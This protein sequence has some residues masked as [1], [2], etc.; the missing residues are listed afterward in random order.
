VFIGLLM[1]ADE[2]DI[3][4][5]T[6]AAHERIIDCF[7]VLDGTVPN[8][9]SEA[10]CRASP[11]CSGYWTDADLPRP[12]Y[13]EDPVDGYRQVLYEAATAEHGFDHWFLLLHADEVWTFDPA[14]AVQEHPE[15]QG[16]IFPLPLYFPR[17]WVDDVPPL[18]QLRWSLRPGYP[19]LRMFRGGPRVEFHPAQH[20]DVT[21]V[22][23]TSKATSQRVIRHYAYRAPAVQRARAARHIETGFDPD[24]HRHIV[25]RDETIWDDSRIASYQQ[26]TYW[27]ELAC[28]RED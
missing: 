15:A 20:F 11:K 10:I 14:Q 12:P 26:Q 9:E 22:G 1:V 13:P 19:E 21:P 18:E 27:T 8:Q 25:D 5:E 4:R 3:L 2:N 17:E 7:Y 24:N 6:L 16:I 28:D 23:V